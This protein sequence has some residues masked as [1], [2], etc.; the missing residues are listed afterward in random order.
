MCEGVYMVVGGGEEWLVSG[1]AE[2]LGERCGF[3]S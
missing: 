2:V 1:V 3:L